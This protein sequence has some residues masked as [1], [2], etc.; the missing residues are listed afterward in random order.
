MKIV[1]SLRNKIDLASQ[2]LGETLERMA[3]RKQEK[4]K[5]IKYY[6]AYGSNMNHK[7]MQYRCPKAKFIVD[8]HIT[9]YELVFRSVADVQ[10]SE[11]SSV[12]GALFEI[13]EDCERSL[14]LYEG[15][16][17]LYTKKYVNRWHGRY[18]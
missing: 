15:Y 3:N 6:F 1:S 8:I 2:S 5:E 10:Q 11:D 9:G 13:T 16:P 4:E 17:N 7:H 14:I 12:T 18:E